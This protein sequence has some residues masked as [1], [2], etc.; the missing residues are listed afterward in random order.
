[1]NPPFLTTDHSKVFCNSNIGQA[2]LEI[3]RS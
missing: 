1:M 3:L 2:Y